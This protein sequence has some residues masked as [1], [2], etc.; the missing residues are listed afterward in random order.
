MKTGT[1]LGWRMRWQP[2]CRQV[3]KKGEHHVRL[4]PGGGSW[5]ARTADLRLV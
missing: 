2:G 3:N 4:F 5:R 1:G